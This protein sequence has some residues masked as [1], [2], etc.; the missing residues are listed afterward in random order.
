M[1]PTDHSIF[2]LY[3]TKLVVVFPALDTLSVFP[4]IAN[5][6]GSNLLAVCGS[7]AAHFITIFTQ[8]LL[9]LQEKV[10]NLIPSFSSSRLE[11]KNDAKQFVTQ[12]VTIVFFRLLASAPP[13]LLSLHMTDLSMPM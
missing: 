9:S 12:R 8:F 13:L 5:T 1:L 7:S 11:K 10:V 4:L 3:A 6:L 2:L